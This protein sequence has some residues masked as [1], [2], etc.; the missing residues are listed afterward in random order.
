MRYCKTCHRRMVS[1]AVWKAMTP[2]ERQ[3]SGAR[4]VD[5]FGHCNP[6]ASR[7][8]YGPTERSYRTR[9]EVLEDWAWLKD[10][11]VTDLQV[12]ADRMGMSF[13]A[14]EKALWRARQDGDE[15]ATVPPR[16][17]FGTGVHIGT[18]TKREQ[19]YIA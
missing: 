10:S 3:D 1:Q 4:R 9:E 11:G 17:N 8:R 7:R 5:S 18:T 6:C 14:L 19:R 13:D 12:A 2:Q 16:Q 15:R